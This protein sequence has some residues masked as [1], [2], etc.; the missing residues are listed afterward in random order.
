HTFAE[1]IQHIEENYSNPK[2]FNSLENDHWRHISTESFIFDLKR[3]THALVSFGLRRGDKVGILA[4]SSPEWNIAD[5]AIIMA[6]GI[7]VPLFARISDESLIYEVAQANIRFLFVQGEKQWDLYDKHRNLF[8]KVIGLDDLGDV[9]GAMK[10]HEFLQMGELFWEKNPKLWDELAHKLNSDDV[11]T[12]IYTSGATGIP[13]G[14]EITHKNLCHLISFPVFG[15][16]KSDSYLSILP[17]A[18]VFAR[19]INLILIAWGISVYYLNDLSRMVPVC[20]E[21]KPSLMIVVPRV[22]EKI[23]SAMEAKIAS[24]KNRFTRWLATWAFNLAKDPNESLLKRFILRPIANLLVYTPLRRTFGGKWRVIICGGAALDQELNHFYV[25]AGF[26]IYEGWGLTEGSTPIV[27]TPG[28]VKLGFI[29]RP[30]PGIK[31][32]LAEKDEV[33]IGGPTVMKGYYR[34]PGATQEAI[35]E[36]GWLHTGDKGAIDEEGFVRLIGRVKE[37]FKLSSG[38]YLVPSRIE[39]MLC[40]NPL[41]D[42]AMVIGEKRKYASCL[43]F[44][45]MGAL[46]RIQKEQKMEDLSDEEFLKSPYVVE[47]IEKLLE[48]INKRINS[49]ERVVK[50]RFILEAPTIEGGEM[51]P[52]LQLKRDIILQKFQDVVSNIYGEKTT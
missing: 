10:Y 32:K 52:T 20:R 40:Q 30:L 24:V 28:K 23:L 46:K 17:L 37:Q 16:R 26:P 22:L 34:N 44:P 36:E 27:N 51:T 29:G 15:W 35:D 14:V 9:A 21:I 33:L 41:I 50:H 38:E 43:L 3:L 31:V 12:I 6:G 2:A 1:V 45:D 18:H 5:F 48:K 8:E 7:T 4:K 11:A 47:E 13:K 19:Q 39:H 49:W 25:H 42:M